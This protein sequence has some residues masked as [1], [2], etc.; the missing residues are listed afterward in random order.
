MKS[1]PLF[2]LAALL[3]ALCIILPSALFYSVSAEEE[4][5]FILVGSDFQEGSHEGSAS[6]VS[7]VIASVKAAGYTAIDGFLFAGESALALN[8]CN[9]DIQFQ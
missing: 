8:M 7:S 5:V 2:R 6:I 3:T 4:S 1:T 9:T